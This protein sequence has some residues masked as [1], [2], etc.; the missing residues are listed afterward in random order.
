MEP[1]DAYKIHVAIKEH[2]WSK[3]DMEKWPYAFKDKYKWGNA[4]S[5]PYR[6]FENKQGMIPMFNMVCDLWKKNEFIAMSVANAVNGCKKCGMPY[7]LESQ[8]VFKEWVARRDR[9]GYQLGQD[10]KT[11]VNAEEKLMGTNTDH[12]VEIRLLLGKHIKIESVVILNQ[13]LPIVDDY[14]RDLI[15]G[16]T[17]LLIK[18][19][20]PFLTESHEGDPPLCNTK[21]L[22]MKHESLINIIARTRNSSNT[23]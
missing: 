13:I 19:Y 6:I 8:Q 9:I 1:Y 12:P 16:D 3:Y 21:M 15:I 4:I 18:R 14:T 11:I 7:G 20:A 22:A 23:S 17:C 2:F 5:I 10:L